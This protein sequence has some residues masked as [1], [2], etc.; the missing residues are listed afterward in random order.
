MS[1]LSSGISV[2]VAAGASVVGFIIDAHG[3]RLGYVFAAA[4]GAA[5]AATCLAGLRRLRPGEPAAVVAE[6]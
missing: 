2:G 6:A 4:C 1:W 5:S 3:P